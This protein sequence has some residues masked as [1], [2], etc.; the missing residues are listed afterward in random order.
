MS[1]LFRFCIHATTIGQYNECLIFSLAMQFFELVPSSKK[2]FF[3]SFS[4]PYIFN[5]IQK[6]ST[7][8]QAF[9]NNTFNKMQKFIFQQTTTSRSPEVH[10]PASSEVLLHQQAM[11]S[12]SSFRSLTVTNTAIFNM[13]HIPS[14]SAAF[15]QGPGPSLSPSSPLGS[16]HILF[17]SVSICSSS[18]I[19]SSHLQFHF[20]I[21]ASHPE[22]LYTVLF[23]EKAFKFRGQPNKQ[24]WI[25]RSPSSTD[26]HH[27]ERRFTD[28]KQH[29]SL[30]L[31]QFI[32]GGYTDLHIQISTT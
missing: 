25:H 8:Q 32:F 26:L 22:V 13:A 30:P 20:W 12:S 28:L 18:I 2:L 4:G 1:A 24:W 16:H 17:D 10:F 5:I 7:S 23:A 3:R 31:V 15:S 21:Y 6:S 27:Q 14:A 11:T 29:R 9:T 19:A